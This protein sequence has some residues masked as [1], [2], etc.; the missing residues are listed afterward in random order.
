MNDRSVFKEVYEQGGLAEVTARL[1]H[2][3]V[4]PAFEKATVNTEEAKRLAIKF[5]KNYLSISYRR[6]LDEVV[7][8][9]TMDHFNQLATEK[10]EPFRIELRKLHDAYNPVLKKR[11]SSLDPNNPD[12]SEEIYAIRM[13]M[14]TIMNPPFSLIREVSTL[15]STMGQAIGLVGRN[16]LV[17][18]P[19]QPSDLKHICDFLQSPPL[20][21]IGNRRL[22]WSRIDHVL[23]IIPSFSAIGDFPRLQNT[24]NLLRLTEDNK[25]AFSDEGKQKLR[26]YSD[27]KIG[28]CP[29]GDTHIEGEDET[30]IQQ[31]FNKFARYLVE[32]REEIIRNIW[33]GEEQ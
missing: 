15:G 17:H 29:L 4:L 24:P 13:A 27:R 31:L 20:D 21:R 33:Q 32:Y 9:E 2:E 10:L 25:L 18:Y 3:Y 23:A 16:I 26:N 7:L 30:I 12:D 6:P 8:S 22:G 14:G 1:L 28:K 19:E 11:L 5:D